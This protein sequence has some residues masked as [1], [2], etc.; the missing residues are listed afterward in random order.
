MKISYMQNIAH[1]EVQILSNS[2]IK[3]IYNIVAISFAFEEAVWNNNLW[4]G[5]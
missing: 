4:L 3:K 1:I 5:V 2:F